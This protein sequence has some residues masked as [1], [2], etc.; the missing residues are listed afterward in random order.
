VRPRRVELEG[1]SAYRDRTVVSFEGADLFA[2]VGPTGSGKSSIIDAIT[3]ALYGSVARYQNTGAVAPVVN[4][5]SAEAKVRLDFELAGVEYTAVRVVRRTKTGATT[6]EARLQRGDEV[7]ASEARSVDDAV[8]ALL[9]LTFEQFTKTVVLPQGEFAAFLHAKASDR[10]DL[11]VRLLDLGLYGEMAASARLRE[12]SAAD[13]L[14][15][16]ERQLAELGEID[17]AAADAAAD[18]ALSLGRLLDALRAQLDDIDAVE[19]D[20]KAL[21]TE[22]ATRF[23]ERKLLARLDVPEAAKDFA[24]ERAHASGDVEAADKALDEARRNRDD[25]AEAVRNGPDERVLDNHREAWASLG[26]VLPNLATAEQR[27]AEL[28]AELAA[29]TD[30]AATREAAFDAAREAHE[31]AVVR[32]G[33]EGLRH[34]LHEG[35]PCP[36][37]EQVVTVLP[38]LSSGGDVRDFKAAVEVAQRGNNQAQRARNKL[39]EDVAK[40]E[41]VVATLVRERDTLHTRL[42]GAPSKI[43]VDEL[44]RNVLVLHGLLESAESSWRQA[45]LVHRRAMKTLAGL[46]DSERKLR[47]EFTATRDALAGLEPPAPHE[48]NILDDWVE[49]VDWGDTARERVDEML[50]AIAVREADLVAK[51]DRLRAFVVDACEAQGIDGR[52]PRLLEVLAREITRAEHEAERIRAAAAQAA[53]L[54]AEA[55]GAREARDVAHELAGLLGARGFEQWLLE[56]ALDELVTGATERL[57]VLSSGAFSLRRDER[58]GFAVV[59]HRNADELR[60]VKTLSG[61]ETFL[62]SLALALALA[63]NV[64]LMSSQSAPKLE[65]IF[66]DEGFGTLDADTLD[67]VAGA[68]EELGATGRMVGVVT[69]IPD[70]A[71]RLPVRYEVS[72]LGTGSMIERIDR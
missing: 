6:K 34:V 72:K 22:R 30:E 21:G 2:F 32:A 28:Q 47:R 45:E 33:A 55:D 48:R 24:D 37:C 65:S 36:V 18:R 71:D 50:D 63:D 62:A 26:A 27:L 15:M 58:G 61:G 46:E 20:L 1:F 64:A 39:A 4:A 44:L 25:A 57:F 69:H 16:I 35:E 68:I 41:T 53:R 31:Q 67:V 5:Q 23:S 8:V 54:S 59:D 51:R 12:R 42:D 11:L 56:E 49:L 38:P 9:G 29:A 60:S 10:Q 43:E 19:A 17:V 7:L 3:F 52:Q 40:Q 14:G 70:L 66:L 13:R